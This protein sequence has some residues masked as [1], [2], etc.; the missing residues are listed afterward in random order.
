MNCPRCQ[1]SNPENAKFCLNCGTALTA[2]CSNC[3]TPLPSGAR[4]CMN[5]GQPVTAASPVDE[6]R[7]TRL[8]ANTPS[9]LAEKMRTAKVTGDRKV[10]TCLFADVVGSTSLAATMD[11]EDWTAIM[12]RA[13][14]RI[15][16]PIYRYE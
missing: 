7:L 4:F 14:D 1:T 15:S 11:A 10:V 6:S 2:V 13:F 16:P 5:C 9:Q 3:N 8:V 12:N